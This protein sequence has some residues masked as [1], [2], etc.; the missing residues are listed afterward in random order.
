MLTQKMLPVN[1]EKYGE[2][3]NLLLLHICHF[4][5]KLNLQLNMCQQNIFKFPL[6]FKIK[7]SSEKTASNLLGNKPAP[8]Y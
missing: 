7:L 8:Y 1:L 4:K 6:H 2:V 5:Y 3:V